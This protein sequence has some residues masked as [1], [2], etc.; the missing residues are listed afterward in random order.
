MVERKR[1]NLNGL[2]L[3]DTFTSGVLGIVGAEKFCEPLK[4]K[5]SSNTL[6]G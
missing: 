3:A 4:K 6:E 2:F 5:D 1:R